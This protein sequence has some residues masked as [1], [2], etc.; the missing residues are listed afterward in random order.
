M[1]IIIPADFFPL[2]TVQ[3]A[4]YNLAP[5]ADHSLQLME[6]GDCAVSLTARGGRISERD[7]PARFHTE[8]TNAAVNNQAHADHRCLREL[9]AQAAFSQT[10]E[11]EQLVAALRDE[12]HGQLQPLHPWGSGEVA[13]D[14]W[15][16]LMAAR[17]SDGACRI[18][19][20]DESGRLSV[21]L[22]TDAYPMPTVLRAI[23]HIQPWAAGVIRWERPPLIEVQLALSP[24]ADPQAVA[25]WFSAALG[26]TEQIRPCLY[27]PAFGVWDTRIRAEGGES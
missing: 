8:L 11:Q 19:P 22:S 23:S 17:R 24:E 7:L 25:A 4:L 21:V 9:F 14:A 1:R 6:G 3:L 27:L 10:E 16:A 2:Q 20:V 26:E 13:P 18:G 15:K 5:V 12:V